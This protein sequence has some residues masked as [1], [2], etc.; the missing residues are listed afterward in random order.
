[1]N[2][3][4][5]NYVPGVCNINPAEIKQ[6]RNAGHLGVA[7]FIVLLAVLVVLDITR[8]VRI[9][10][11]FPAILAAIGYLQ[12]KNK[13]CVGYGGAGMQ[14]ADDDP[15][16]QQVAKDAAAIDKKRAQKINLQAIMI[17]LAA[18]LASLL[19]P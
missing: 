17:G 4:S 16:A 12:A 8:W 7:L 11:V 10:L 6:R 14:H 19:I 3:P 5:T 15:A 18:A 9:L 13:F 2:T 1:M